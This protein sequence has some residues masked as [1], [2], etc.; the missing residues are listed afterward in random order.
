[1]IAGEAFDHIVFTLRA[2]R[3]AAAVLFEVLYV[4]WAGWLKLENPELNE[5][6]VWVPPIGAL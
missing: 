3:C 6:Y 2:N 5:L 4:L 1:M